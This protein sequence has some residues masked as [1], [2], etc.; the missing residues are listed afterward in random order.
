MCL[1]S[2]L[3]YLACKS[4]PFWVGLYCHLWP[5]CLYHIFARYVINDTIFGKK[6]LNIKCVFWFSLQLLSEIFLILGRIQRDI[7]I[8]AYRFPC[9]VPV[10][11][12]RCDWNLNFCG[13]FSKNTQISNFMKIRPV[14]DELF[15]SDGWTDTTKVT[16]AF[17]NFANAP[18]NTALCSRYVLYG[19]QNKQLLFPYTALTDCFL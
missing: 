14:W 16:V 8:N 19:S 10:T 15:H 2:C 3:S 13:K 1:Y 4:H 18:K 12:V 17:R 6:K 7:I 11:L 5:L 9:K